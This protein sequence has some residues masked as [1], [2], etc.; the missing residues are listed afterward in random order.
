HAAHSQRYSA[1]WR[2][3]A[4]DSNSGGTGGGQTMRGNITRRGKSSWRLKFDLGRDQTGRRQIRYET[5]RGKRADAERK[6]AELL[7]SIGQGA[8]VEPAAVTVA[9]HVRSRIDQWQADGDITVRTA[10]RYRELVEYQIIPHLGT[11]LLQKL[12]TVDIETW[13]TTL[14][15]SGR[16]DGK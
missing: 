8:Y 6:L 3:E 10:E 12:R 9:D 1:R 11:K 13:H 14:R 16:K 7:A 5:V 4:A 2:S 15:T